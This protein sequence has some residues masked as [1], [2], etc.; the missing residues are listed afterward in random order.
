[1]SAYG[2]SATTAYARMGISSMNGKTDE[3]DET[4]SLADFQT[5][6]SYARQHHLARLTF[7]SVNRDRQRGSGLGTDSCSGVSQSAF[8]YP[9]VFVQYTG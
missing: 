8:S 2:Y 4:V 3:S 5:F 1:M 9:K 7:W 6:L